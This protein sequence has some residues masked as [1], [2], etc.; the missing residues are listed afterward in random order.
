MAT[1]SSILARR[2]PW[3]EEPGGLQSVGF[4]ES[5]TTQQLTLAPFTF[6]I[7]PDTMHT[8]RK[9]LFRPEE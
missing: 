7:R 2:I 9:P 1:Y 6:T 5:D 4:K 3:P 8:L